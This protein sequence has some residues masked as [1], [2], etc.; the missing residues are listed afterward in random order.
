M[1]WSYELFGWFA[2]AELAETP[3]KL[4]I[5][6]PEGLEEHAAAVEPSRPANSA[7]HAARRPRCRHR[8]RIADLLVGLLPGVVRPRWSQRRHALRPELA[9]GGG[10]VQVRPALREVS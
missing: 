5:V 10:A 6:R 1:S 2:I 4:A 9:Q 8:D 7:A 3:G